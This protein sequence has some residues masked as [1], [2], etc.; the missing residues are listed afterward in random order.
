MLGMGY[1]VASFVERPGEADRGW[2]VAK[3]SSDAG[4]WMV[5]GAIVLIALV[6]K[7]V[8]IALGVV[9]GLAVAVYVG[10]KLNAARK[11]PQSSARVPAVHEPTLAE[12]M[13]SN[14]QTKPPS[15]TTVPM[16][17]PSASSKEWRKGRVALKENSGERAQVFPANS[18]TGAL[19]DSSHQAL[20][21][22]TDTTSKS[23]T[24]KI[25][26]QPEEWNATRQVVADTNRER[27]RNLRDKFPPTAPR[28][29]ERAI[30]PGRQPAPPSPLPSLDPTRAAAA[31]SQ[32]PGILSPV[33]SPDRP[34]T[35]PL[36]DS[37]DERNAARQVALDTNIERARALRDFFS[38]ARLGTTDTASSSRT[39]DPAQPEVW[40]AARQVVADTNRER[41]Q[42]MRD[43]FPSTAPREESER[44]TTP[45][46]PTPPASLLPSLSPTIAPASK[47]ERTLGD[48]MRMFR[49][50]PEPERMYSAPGATKPPPVHALP[51]AP[52]GFRET[53]WVRPDETVQ[54]SGL[55]VPGGMFYFGSKLKAANGSTEPALINPQLS[56]AG[57]GN[58]R[59]RHTNYWPSYSEI[60]PTARR[61]YLRWL[62]EGRSHPECDIGL[63]FLFFYGLERRVFIDSQQDK[64]TKGDW[65]TILV[66]IRRLL[67]IYGEKSTSFNRY[68]SELL[69]WLE[70]DGASNRLY[71]QP[72]PHFPRTYEVPPY[73]RLALGQAAVDR[74]PLPATLALSWVRLSPDCYLRTAATRCPEEFERLF[75]QRYH[76]LLGHG[77]ILPKNRTKLKFIYQPASGGL[78]GAKITMGFDDVPDATALTAPIKTLREI[79][80]Q[81]TNELGSYSRLVGR[82][83]KF[84]SS[85]EGLLLLPASLWP[86]AARARLQELAGRMRN[87]RL[88]LPL[89]ELFS[90]LGASNQAAS[91][92]VVR[93]L[94]RALEGEQIGIEPHV[95]GGA[96]TPGENDA[97]VLFSQPVSD[98][99]VVSRAEFQTG[100]LTLQLAAALAMADGTFHAKEAE[101]LRD[102]IEGW[103]HLTQAERTRLHAHL[104][105]L[106]S[107]PPTLASL[108]KKL[109]PL[110][111]AAR[112]AIATVMASLAQSD[113]FVSPDEV[114]FLEKIYKA[115]GVETKRVFSDVHAAS[116]GAA[117]SSSKRT[118]KG[119]FRLDADRIAAL[120]ADTLRVSA[121]LS[122]IFTE[123]AVPAAPV[124]EPEPVAA[125]TGSLLALDAAHS[126]LLR[127]MI[128]RPSWSRAEL[129]DAAA[130]LELMLD[131]A[132]EQINE[133]AFEAFDAPLCEG[134]DPVD[135]N[136]ELLEKLEA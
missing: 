42:A 97:V 13:A 50:S 134:D 61:A 56:V 107:A 62:A 108:K 31:N 25:P 39:I 130:D 5:V 46:P 131:G 132:L 21:G 71:E 23:R 30:T 115:L 112:E 28:I 67:S 128:S 3:R 78:Q 11:H 19:H 124:P 17:S 116:S 119:R 37:S 120:Q 83:A 76:E 9:V 103:T 51:S 102:E 53:R 135:V 66:E 98:A 41:A 29:S 133:A 109:E 47:P 123:E 72:V 59:E 104:H 22:T 89:R 64:T 105:W 70:L 84:A 73:V 100:A 60:S 49:G 24:A 80:E 88:S 32:N 91:R 43:K 26:A 126:A 117:P 68:G 82:D 34:L 16:S 10:V 38:Q 4:L 20:A 136:S 15:P 77:L 96:K 35:N 129:D 1:R 75:A 85:L 44:V 79:A 113:G 101:H 45:G 14:P 36:T 27:A 6:P 114:K 7:E 110:S 48:F 86:P 65:P 58:F 106:T 63:V 127:L 12:W 92:E 90:A 55:I 95:L 87:G 93:A 121:L 122:K 2:G 69:S 118:D 54:I 74:K 125:V 99:P 18:P 8:W 57:L 52:D 81:C 94:A 111:I 33:I 40:S